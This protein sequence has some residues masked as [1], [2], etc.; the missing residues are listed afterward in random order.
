MPYVPQSSRRELGDGALPATAGE[1]N[2]CITAMVDDYLP[3]SPSY[4]DVNEVLGVLEAAKL[5]V[6]RRI[7]VPHED[8]KIRENGDVFR[9]R[10]EAFQDR[11]A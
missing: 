5:E 10:G 8:R 9:A 4:D 2:Y 1:L 7:L 3:D 11:P 6:F